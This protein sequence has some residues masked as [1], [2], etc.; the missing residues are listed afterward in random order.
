MNY[1]AKIKISQKDA[2]FIN[3]CLQQQILGEEET[4]TETAIFPDSCQMDIKLCGADE[5][6]A[7][8]EAV[9]YDEEGRQ[10]CFSDVMDEF[11]GEW[12][13]M[14]EN[15]LYTVIVEV[16][17]QEDRGMKVSRLY[18]A[19]ISDEYIRN[20]EVFDSSYDEEDMDD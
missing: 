1:I 5:E 18:I 9:L 15:N 20:S 7:W 13:L 8:T 11:I 14:H 10:L 6:S 3:K 4:Y 19:L 17:T 2:D 12:E 16:E